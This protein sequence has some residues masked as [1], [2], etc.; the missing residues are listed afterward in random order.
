MTV[1]DLI[2]RNPAFPTS[3]VVPHGNNYECYYGNPR[4]L[5]GHCGP[6][7]GKMHKS[8][9][10][11]R[12]SSADVVSVSLYGGS[13]IVEGRLLADSVHDRN[14]YYAENVEWIKAHAGEVRGILVGNV[15]PELSFKHRWLNDSRQHRKI[16]SELMC[17]L[18]SEAS[19]IILQAGGTPV[20]PTIDWDVAVDFY[21]GDSIFRDYCNDISA[22]QLCFCGYQLFGLATEGPWPRI[23]HPDS[24]WFW[25]L[26]PIDDPLPRVELQEYIKGGVFWTGCHGLGGMRE[27]LDAKLLDIG[28]TE[29]VLSPGELY[30]EL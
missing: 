15:G 17:E 24:K 26:C 19:E 27:G 5:T 9:L 2:G 13:S 4:I 11:G 16:L 12:I 6:A 21:Y 3:I 7:T 30:P 18:A 14:H 1:A 20:F 10:D 8:E 29:G 25:P 28:F 23:P 22:I